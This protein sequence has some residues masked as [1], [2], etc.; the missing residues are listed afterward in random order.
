MNKIE[1]K[2]FAGGALQEQF[3]K[4]FE[5]II[6]NL[7]DPNTSFKTARE[8]NIK[9]KFTQNERRDDVSVVVAVG[10]KLAP[11]E[12]MTTSFAIGKNLATGEMYAE[13]YGKGIRGQMSI[14][15]FTTEQETAAESAATNND[16]IIDFRRTT[17]N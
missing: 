11:Q 13:E 5:K 7:Q 3:E 2:D 14:N 8:I 6:E 16:S 17:A 1:L 4:S 12:A 15:D 9:L 10:E